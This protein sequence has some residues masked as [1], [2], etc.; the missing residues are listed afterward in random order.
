M[1][2][3]WLAIAAFT[4]AF[5]MS[6]E[7]SAA[8][9]ATTF[10]PISRFVPSGTTHNAY[11][12][13][14][15]TGEQRAVF[16]I[17]WGG[18]LASL[19]QNGVERAWGHA[20]GGMVQPAFHSFPNGQDYNPTLAGDQ[21]NKGSAV[22]GVRCVDANTLYLIS[23]TLDYNRGASG[24]I[25]SNTVLNGAV[26]PNSYATPYTVVTIATFVANPSGPPSY[27][28]KIQQTITNIDPATNVHF[29]FELA[30][31]VPYTYT[32]QVRYPAACATVDNNCYNSS[33]PDL[34]GGLYPNANLTGGIAFFV[35]PQ[36]SWNPS[37][38]T[39][40]SFATD[41]INQN[42][43]THLFTENWIL[44]PGVSRTVVWYVLTG[45][46]SK[47]LNFASLI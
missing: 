46:W 36:A 26:V 4:F 5:V 13:T 12:L 45:D 23:G 43:S 38:R 20:T 15:P 39:F 9:G 14:D 1:K 6:H 17:V 41:T 7:A 21:S 27:Y 16:D 30:G 19:K 31:Y 47:A 40:V 35:S 28:L 11:Y 37:Q 2:T 25:I 29:G 24:F 8:C 44:G 32:S 3:L 34:L 22:M 18:A 10:Q 42:Q 33:T